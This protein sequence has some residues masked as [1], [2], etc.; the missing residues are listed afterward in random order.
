MAQLVNF[1]LTP[2]RER[3]LRYVSDFRPSLQ[4]LAAATRS[5]LPQIQDL[6]R[7]GLVELDDQAA[8]Q[9]T[10]EGARALEAVDAARGVSEVFECADAFGV[11][12]ER[13]EEA[14]GEQLG[15]FESGEPG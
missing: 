3:A 5:V 1:R 11:C 12:V 9:L 2:K 7:A 8:A 4:D 6:R 10:G 14:R 13:R 15:L